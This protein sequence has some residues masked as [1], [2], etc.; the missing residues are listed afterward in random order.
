VTVGFVVPEPI[1]RELSLLI[2]WNDFVV[3]VSLAVEISSWEV[4][5]LSGAIAMSLIGALL[6]VASLNVFNAAGWLCARWAEL[7]L[8]PTRLPGAAE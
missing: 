6:L 7:V 2:P 3:G 1:T 8:D 5:T 4:T